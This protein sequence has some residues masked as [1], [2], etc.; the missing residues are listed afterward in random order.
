MYVEIELVKRLAINPLG[1]V[2]NSGETVVRA[3]ATIP[4]ESEV[5]LLLMAVGGH[6]VPNSTARQD[7]FQYSVWYCNKSM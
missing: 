1:I 5:I 3:A 7:N 2:L 4:S 6:Y